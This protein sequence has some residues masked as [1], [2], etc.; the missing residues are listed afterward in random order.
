MTAVNVTVVR[1]R[2][3]AL[4][5]D[6]GMR[7]VFKSEQGAY[8]SGDT[9]YLQ[10]PELTWDKD[11]LTL[12]EGQAYHEIG[13][14]TE[15][16]RDIF[17]VIKG[18]DIHMES[19]FG[20][21]LNSLDD[22]RQEHQQYGRYRGRDRLMGD[23][24]ALATSYQKTE[25]AFSDKVLKDPK[26]TEHDKEGIK[27]YQ[28]LL[29]YMTFQ[30]ESMYP[31]CAGNT[32]TILKEMDPDVQETVMKL[33][34]HHD[35]LCTFG[36][37]ADGVYE[38]TKR[39]LELLG[40]DP[41]EKEKEAQDAAKAAKQLSE[42]AEEFAKKVWEHLHSDEEVEAHS[43]EGRAGPTGERPPEED[44]FMSPKD[45][46]EDYEQ[47]DWDKMMVHD[48]PKSPATCA[49]ST[50]TAQLIEEG[51]FLGTKVKK[52]LQALSINRYEHGKKRGRLGKNLHRATMKQSG[53]YQEKIFKQRKET[54]SLDVALELLVDCSG[55]MSGYKYKHACAAAAI[56]LDV[57]NQLRIP[58]EVTG[59]TETR[60]DGASIYDPVLR[61]AIFK[62]FASHTNMEQLNSNF[63]DFGRYKEQN[64]DGES[65]LWAAFRLLKQKTRRKILIVF[66]D[67][68]PY[69]H[70]HGAHFITHKVVKELEARRDMEIYGIGIHDD[71][72]LEYYK[73]CRVIDHS[74]A[75][76]AALLDVI[77][78]KIL[79]GDQT[80]G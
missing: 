6:K 2:V 44:T 67:G 41:E 26:L 12:W 66:S 48:Y 36:C 30:F 47:S 29:G 52:L 62:S 24:K 70:R 17:D 63:R 34:D 51:R 71:S 61:H 38:R 13:H 40:Y 75:L 21:A 4:T 5:E 27:F 78:T 18:K 65:I 3:R 32:E 45:T 57:C 69:A 33:I 56:M 49:P 25:G 60:R 72:V 23:Y 73:D 50:G 35:E 68:C 1:N 74:E 54:I 9:I 76:E 77:K 14:C 19:I 39:L 79:D 31:A 37:D 7:L 42:A 28:K 43:S 80:N 53:S 58:C 8:T 59:F 11:R 46:S 64:L 16:N 15:E 55:S 22:P 20:R 10:R